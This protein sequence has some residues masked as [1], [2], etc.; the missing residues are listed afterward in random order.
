MPV[1]T[2][3]VYREMESSSRHIVLSR[4][5]VLYGRVGTYATRTA[6]LKKGMPGDAGLW[7]KCATSIMQHIVRP[8]RAS[9]TVDVFV[10]SWNLELADQ[11]DDHWRPM[12]SDHAEQNFS[13]GRCAIKLNYCDRTMWA[14][15]GM[16][17]AL[18][19]RTSWVASAGGRD[20]PPHATVLVM[21]HDVFWRTPLPP[22]R[23]D[24]SVRL[25]LPFD[26]QKARQCG[27]KGIGHA[28]PGSSAAA[29]A[30]QRERCEDSSTG[31][32]FALS[33]PRSVLGVKCYGSSVDSRALTFCG[34]S[35]NI[36]WW[37]AGDV[38]L[39]DSFGETSDRFA[40]YSRLVRVHG[41]MRARIADC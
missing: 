27:Q 5:V 22:L 12:A 8:W 23:S 9:G 18:A 31:D 13:L 6:S 40:D 38:A 15:L 14:L 16:R 29:A 26:C 21:R 25:W 19:L 2:V 20:K 28:H 7:R 10:Q 36:D 41:D 1:Y 39:A 24:R 33:A 34:N 37:W 17:R 32:W 3:P 30:H 4:A 11:M 35:V